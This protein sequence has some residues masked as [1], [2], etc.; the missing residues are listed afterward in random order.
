MKIY[1]LGSLNIDYV[2]SV[3]H[4]VS[5]GETEASKGMNV[6]PGGKG[7]NQSVAIAK[8][9]AQFIH[10]AIVGNGSEFLV[11]TLTDVGVDTTR[12]KK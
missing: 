6:F 10:G 11:N 4:F 7:L 5:A 3:D 8:A 1:N 9:G 12:I 2:Y